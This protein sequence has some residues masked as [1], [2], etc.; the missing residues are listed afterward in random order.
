MGNR[1]VQPSLLGVGRVSK[2]RL[3]PAQVWGRWLL[4]LY[5]PL[6]C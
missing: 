6:L 1:K 5:G 4:F 2:D 3:Q